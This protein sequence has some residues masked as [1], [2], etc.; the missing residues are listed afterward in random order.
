MDPAVAWALFRLGFTPEA[1][2]RVGIVE[3]LYAGIR[4]NG[5]TA[6]ADAKYQIAEWDDATQAIS[7]D[8]GVG[9]QFSP[10]PSLVEDATLTERA[11][12]T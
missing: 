5:T 12:T 9:R 2:L 11:L 8:M 10:A 6:K 4:Y 1:N 7:V 3:N